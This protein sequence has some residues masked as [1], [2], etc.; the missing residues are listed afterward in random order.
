M[1]FNKKFAIPT[2]R[3]LIKSFR[4]IQYDWSLKTPLQKW[5]Y[6]YG[7]GRAACII[8]AIPFF[9][10]DQTL[11]PCVYQLSFYAGIYFLLSIYTVY[12]HLIRG[13]LEKCLPCT[14]QLSLIAAVRF[15]FNHFNIYLLQLKSL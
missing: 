2:V 12:F 11:S 6:F 14:C 15:E 5:C 13:E 3:E 7:I 8:T 10:D 1:V 4:T 9:E